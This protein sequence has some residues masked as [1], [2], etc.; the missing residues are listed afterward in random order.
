[1]FWGA[2]LL[3]CASAVQIIGRAI[4]EFSLPR[5]NHPC[6]L[7]D[8]R[9]L[10]ELEQRLEE[11]PQR[12]L[13]LRV[14]A[15]AH[16]GAGRT[17]DWVAYSR[18]VR[19]AALVYAL[20]RESWA[21]RRAARLLAHYP[22][23]FSGMPRSCEKLGEVALNWAQAYDLMH[24]YLA[25]RG[26]KRQATL[27]VARLAHRL[28][29]S[30]R[31]SVGREVDSR[32]AWAWRAAAL[33][34]C[35]LALSG[36]RVP[37]EFASPRAWY[38]EG[39]GELRRVL[40]QAA[41]AEFVWKAGVE[42]VRELARAVV[43]VALAIERV[44]GEDPLERSGWSRVMRWMLV[45]TLPDGRRLSPATGTA[46]LFPNYLAVAW[47]PVAL[48]FSAQVAEH[49]W[50]AG[51]EPDA[52]VPL[53]LIRPIEAEDGARARVAVLGG[54]AAL[55]SGWSREPMVVCVGPRYVVGAAAHEGAEALIIPMAGAAG[56]DCWLGEAVVR[57]PGK[58][59]PARAVMLWWIRRR[60]TT[61]LT[62]ECEAVA[63]R[64]GPAL[65]EWEDS[66]WDG[67][68]V[69]GVAT[70]LDSDACVVRVACRA[71]PASNISLHASSLMRVY[72]QG[73]Q[74]CERNALGGA[75]NSAERPG[76]RE[77]GGG[78]AWTFVLV[79]GRR[80]CAVSRAEESGGWEVACPL[81]GHRWHLA[82]ASSNEP[83]PL[84]AGD[85]SSRA[86][87]LACKRSPEGKVLGALIV[88]GLKMGRGE[89]VAWATDKPTT[90]WWTPQAGIELLALR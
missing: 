37:A 55:R 54:A 72:G 16:E 68:S 64:G 22:T 47:K 70:V 5:V 38:S 44:S 27:A 56:A 13:Y 88:G 4:C 8:R 29:F 74:A 6:L 43:P 87:M 82:A 51:E 60:G 12:S 33:C 73:R 30:S 28:Y 31:S 83:A 26:R 63:A 62:S 86:R 48:E 39:R 41:R 53:C 50:Q 17:A 20:E 78:R 23:A 84:A 14:E 34:A 67:L 75:D 85:V 77:K 36:E 76:D 45:V 57:A 46:A 90:A 24:D 21:G 58:R 15:L 19:A 66:G 71:K 69:A 81:A 18:S 49:G 10:R 3:M 1:M 61:N 7:L 11:E 9:G 52:V 89:S 40:R 59:R 2:L 32:V 79:P 65:V 42:G 35:A 25:K 80:G